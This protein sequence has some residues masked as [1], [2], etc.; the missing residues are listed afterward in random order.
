[1][2][3]EAMISLLGI[4]HDIRVIGQFGLYTVKFRCLA[5]TRQETQENSSYYENKPDHGISNVF[6]LKRIAGSRKINFSTLK[7]LRD[8]MWILPG[9][10][11]L[12]T[13]YKQIGYF[14][15]P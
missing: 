13:Y 14:C 1:M 11:L 8:I 6:R 5:K 2:S 15:R 12:T 4:D 7:G 9:K 3:P 10:D